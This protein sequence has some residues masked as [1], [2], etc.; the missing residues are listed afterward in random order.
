MTRTDAVTRTA[1]SQVLAPIFDTLN[2]RGSTRSWLAGRL[3]L[4][5]RRLWAFEHGV[6]RMP[7]WFVER[8][9]ATLGIPSSF[10]SIPEP[11][12][13]YIQQPRTKAATKGQPDNA[14]LSP[15]ATDRNR[16]SASASVSAPEQP[17]RSR[18]ARASTAHPTAAR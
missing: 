17:I 18:R 8:A 12:D 16:R 14:N 13:L 2:A 3:E 7:P 4:D 15:R 11:R 10:V 5:R 6:E 9:C 1:R